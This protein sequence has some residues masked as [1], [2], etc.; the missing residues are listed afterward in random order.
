MLGV[1]FR[2][3]Y[4]NL[5]RTYINS[6]Y[7]YIYVCIYIYVYTCVYIYVDIYVYMYIYI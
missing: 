1:A 3:A 5:P 2:V 4:H 7:I 6:G